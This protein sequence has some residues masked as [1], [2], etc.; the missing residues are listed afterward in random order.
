MEMNLT[1]RRKADPSAAELDS[2]KNRPV[3]SQNPRKSQELEASGTSENRDWKQVLAEKL[4]M[5]QTSRLPTPIL[6]LSQLTA[7]LSFATD[8]KF[9]IWRN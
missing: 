9:N 6:T 3:L 8:R 7:P 1:T 2:D 5:K 4:Y